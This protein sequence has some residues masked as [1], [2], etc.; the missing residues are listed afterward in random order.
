MDDLDGNGLQLGK[1][2][3]SFSSSGVVSSTTNNKHISA[4]SPLDNSLEI[5]IYLL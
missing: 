2:G 4:R 3:P 1:V 5:F